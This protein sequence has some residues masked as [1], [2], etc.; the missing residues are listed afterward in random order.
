MFNRL[1]RRSKQ[2]EFDE[3]RCF[4]YMNMD[5]TNF[6]GYTDVHFRLHTEDEGNTLSYDIEL[7]L[8]KDSKPRE[9][10][11]AIRKFADYLEDKLMRVKNG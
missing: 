9:A 3:V 2:I 5:V 8:Y 11:D 1:F 6:Y 4:D 10:A 7:R